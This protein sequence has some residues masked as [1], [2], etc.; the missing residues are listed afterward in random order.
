M[1]EK[2]V[3]IRIND[4]AIIGSI[5]FDESPQSLELQQTA[6]GYNL[7]IPALVQ[8]DWNDRE[9]PHPILSNVRSIVSCY[10]DRGTK[11]ELGRI[12]DDSVYFGVTGGTGD[13]ARLDW[14]NVGPALVY[15][16]GNRQESSPKLNFFVRAELQFLVKAVRVHPPNVI[17]VEP[18]HNSV[19]SFPHKISG[20]V[21]VTYPTNVWNG[22]V[23][24]IFN[25]TR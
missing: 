1:A 8:V 2:I 12:R 23:A 22:L 25:P 19:V 5:R 14:I 20:E 21:D 16:E 11:V 4:R 6:L 24:S 13:D 10:T 7:R 17:V 9:E 18:G 15:L 3:P